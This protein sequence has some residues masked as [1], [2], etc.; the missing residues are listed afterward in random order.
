MKCN[1]RS[2]V[3][4]EVAAWYKIMETKLPAYSCCV[5]GDAR[6]WRRC[7]EDVIE[8]PNDMAMIPAL[9]LGELVEQITLIETEP[10][11]AA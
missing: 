4:K 6:H 10:Q 1:P 3:Y 8:I 9:A 2:R 7:L 5:Q 11:S